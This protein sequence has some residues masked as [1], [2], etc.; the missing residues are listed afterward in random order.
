MAS[1]SPGKLSHA[2]WL[3]LANRL[4]RTYIST[5]KPSESLKELATFIIKVYAPVWFYIKCN[6]TIKD[7][8]KN[9]FRTIYFSRYLKQDLKCI[10]D[11]AI[12]HNGFYA[13]P[14]NLL[15]AM[16][17]DERKHI[18]ELAMRRI[19]S[20]RSKRSESSMRKFTIPAINFDAKDYIDLIN[21]QKCDVT[22]PPLT[23]PLPNEVFE[24]AMELESRVLP[25]TCHFPGHTQAV[26]RIIKLVT[27]ASL[28][29]CGS[30][31]RDGYIRAGI[32]DLKIMPKF[33]TKSKYK[34]I[35]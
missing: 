26:E 22:E 27:E 11:K 8:S 19:I 29:V 34:P 32:L 30:L 16:L 3:T 9:L 21:W 31:S 14:E 10:V 7:A 24:K 13:H 1:R 2:R 20:I 6:P 23:K 12:Q 5:T 35:M 28:E 17:T 33:G 4:L 18:R 15:V 25:L